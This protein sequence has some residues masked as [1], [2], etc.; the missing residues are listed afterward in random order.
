MQKALAAQEKQ[1]LRLRAREANTGPPDDADLEMAGLVDAQ[2]AQL[3]YAALRHTDGWEHQGGVC[4]LHEERL[5]LTC[6]LLVPGCGVEASPGC[7]EDSHLPDVC[8]TSTPVSCT[9]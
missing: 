2:R 5:G 4:R 3:G 8:L 9:M 6:P 7:Q 1:A